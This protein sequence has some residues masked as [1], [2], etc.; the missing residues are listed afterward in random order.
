[1]KL[2]KFIEGKRSGKVDL[3]M[4][5]WCRVVAFLGIQ[6]LGSKVRKFPIQYHF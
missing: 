2:K 1:M 3:C 6:Q 5:Q 4:L